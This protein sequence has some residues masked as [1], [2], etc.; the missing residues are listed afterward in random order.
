MVHIPNDDFPKTP[1]RYRGNI[2]FQGKVVFAICLTKM[3]YRIF[4][5]AC[6]QLLFSQLGMTKEISLWCPDTSNYKIGCDT[7]SDHIQISC[8]TTL[9]A[10]FGRGRT[11][12]ETVVQNF[13]V[14]CE[15]VAGQATLP[16]RMKQVRPTHSKKQLARKDKTNKQKKCTFQLLEIEARSSCNLQKQLRLVNRAFKQISSISKK[17]K[18]NK[19]AVLHERRRKQFAA[20]L[21][22]MRK[23]PQRASAWLDKMRHQHAGNA[24]MLRILSI[25]DI[26]VDKFL[27]NTS[28][29]K[30]LCIY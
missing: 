1:E 28:I 10:A 25:F 19:C 9:R 20:M 8:D 18:K 26:F 6:Q 22:T 12:G 13:V 2:I 21:V 23:H 3:D 7:I 30:S 11:S 5:T 17:G 15:V 29:S 27:C 14:R 4:L 16:K 24:G